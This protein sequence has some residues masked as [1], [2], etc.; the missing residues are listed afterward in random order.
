MPA[1]WA[2]TACVGVKVRRA[3]GS[4]RAVSA[5]F[6]LEVGSFGWWRGGNILLERVPVLNDFCF[7]NTGRVEDFRLWI[8]R[9]AKHQSSLRRVHFNHTTGLAAGMPSQDRFQGL[10]HRHGVPVG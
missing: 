5:R 1:L 7:L 6:S 10:N 4:T 3:R 2:R 8:S 9:S